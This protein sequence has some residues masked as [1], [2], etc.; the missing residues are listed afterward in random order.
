MPATSSTLAG[1]FCAGQWIPSSGADVEHRQ[2][3][4][5]WSDLDSVSLGVISR[6]RTGLLYQLMP[7]SDKVPQTLARVASMSPRSTVIR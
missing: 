1:L 5:S 2:A 4:T 7:R 6:P 3:T